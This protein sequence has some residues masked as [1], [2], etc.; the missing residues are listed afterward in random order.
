MLV[1]SAQSP[2]VRFATCEWVH[3][4]IVLG[5]LVGGIEFW[6]T[7]SDGRPVRVWLSLYGCLLALMAVWLLLAEAYR[8]QVG[9]FPMNSQAAVAAASQRGD[10]SWAARIGLLRGELWSELTYTYS[11]LDWI[12]PSSTPPQDLTEAVASALQTLKLLP[13]D[14]GVWL[15]L[16]DLSPRLSQP[17]VKPV[18]A[19]KMSYY[20]GANEDDLVPLRMLTSAR[21]DTGADPELERLFQDQVEMVLSARPELRPALTSAYAVATPQARQLIGAA[22]ARVDP[23]FTQLLLSRAP[24]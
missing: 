18:E 15:M 1:C 6:P 22:A 12:D 2:T 16:A 5:Y 11:A 17:A 7:T 23:S 10:A 14:A 13:A 9:S 8:S 4:K 24:R 21:I 20:T 19:L 3:L